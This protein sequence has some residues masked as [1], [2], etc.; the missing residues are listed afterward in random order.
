MEIWHG[1]SVSAVGIESDRARC[2]CSLGISGESN[3]SSG[4]PLL[5]A[6]YSPR[7]MVVL[8]MEGRLRVCDI[9]LLE[10]TELSACERTETSRS[11]SVLR[12]A[13]E[14]HG[15]PIAVVHDPRVCRE[16]RERRF[17]ARNGG[18]EG[19]D[20][21]VQLP[22]RPAALGKL[23]HCIEIGRGAALTTTHDCRIRARLS[24]D[25]RPVSIG[26]SHLFERT[27]PSKRPPPLSKSAPRPALLPLLP[28]AALLPPTRLARSIPAIRADA[29][30]FAAPP[31]APQAGA[32][33]SGRSA[34]RR[35]R[36]VSTQPIH[37]T[38]IAKLRTSLPLSSPS[39]LHTD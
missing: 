25:A 34:P 10:K 2:F 5:T 20:T 19:G 21:L 31:R 16:P 29:F 23:L 8:R 24:P 38:I 4:L 12:D 22:T 11:A 33:Q 17:P 32:A 13:C 26:L 3:A 18:H 30:F 9:S 1:R 6:E 15:D 28:F 7:D 27:P 36:H 35:T 39:T 14:M 37:A